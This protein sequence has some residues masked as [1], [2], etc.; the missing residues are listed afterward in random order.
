[1]K[2][3]RHH[4]INANQPMAR[5]SGMNASGMNACKKK[6]SLAGSSSVS[7]VNAGFP[8]TVPMT[9][10]KPFLPLGK[11]SAYMNMSSSRPCASAGM[12]MNLTMATYTHET[13]VM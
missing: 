5:R 9:Q 13:P 10:A 4:G 2:Q 12:A 11:S 3:N 1:M 8:S 7:R 6:M